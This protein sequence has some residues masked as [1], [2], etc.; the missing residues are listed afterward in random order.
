MTSEKS[1]RNHKRY[2]LPS[3]F[4]PFTRSKHER[5]SGWKDSNAMF[6]ELVN[7]AF[8]ALYTDLSSC[9]EFYLSC[10]MLIPYFKT[11]LNILLLSEDTN[12]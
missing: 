8:E 9:Y 6:T 3:A 12:R 7:I 11:K 4:S 1:S 5:E 2:V 10:L